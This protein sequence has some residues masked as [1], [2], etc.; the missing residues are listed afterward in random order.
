MKKAELTGKRQCTLP[1]AVRPG[2][3]NTVAVTVRLETKA[4]MGLSVQKGHLA[5]LLSYRLYTYL[6]AFWIPIIFTTIA[7]KIKNRI[8]VRLA[9]LKHKYQ[10]S[11]HSLVILQHIG[12][13]YGRKVTIT[14]KKVQKDTERVQF[15][16]SISH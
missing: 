11:N 1:A 15:M 9:I 8:D 13:W 16:T 12:N 3:A 10:L 14:K 4:Y 7:I 6:I 2:S 5:T